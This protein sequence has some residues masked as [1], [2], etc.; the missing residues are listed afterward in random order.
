MVCYKSFQ[1]KW[2]PAKPRLSEFGNK[3]CCNYDG[4]A[5]QHILRELRIRTEPRKVLVVI[6]DGLPSGEFNGQRMRQPDYIR[7]IESSHRKDA[8]HLLH[9]IQDARKAGIEVLG[10]GILSPASR[11]FYEYEKRGKKV[12]FI[13]VDNVRDFP[14]TFTKALQDMLLVKG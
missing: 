3:T 7:Y 8:N 6:S 5:V 12:G 2:T 14:S 13:N 1:E 4:E 9:T 11:R 10:V